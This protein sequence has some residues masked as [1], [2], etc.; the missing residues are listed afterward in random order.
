MLNIGRK[1][2]GI[3][4]AG[5]LH[6]YAVAHELHHPAMICGCL[7]LDELA[8]MTLQ[9]GERARFVG[10]HEAAEADNVSRQDGS[11]AALDAGFAHNSPRVRKR[12][13]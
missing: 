1:V 6:K 13:C 5:E 12:T 3:D 2:D 8:M 10:S 4:N 9:L 7:R 11:Q